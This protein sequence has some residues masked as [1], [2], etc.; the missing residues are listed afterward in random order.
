M[1]EAK[2]EDII[3]PRGRQQRGRLCLAPRVTL[4]ELKKRRI[5]FYNNT[6]LEFCNYSEIFPAIKKHMEKLGIR[7]FVDYRETVRGRS[8]EDLR[9]TA[10]ELAKGKF[11]AAVVALA[12]MGTS[13]ATTVLAI[14]MEKAGIPTVLISAP[15]GADLAEQ[16]AFY[17]AG[18][19]CLCPI[20]IFQA[21][22]KEAVAAEI[23]KQMDCVIES[24]IL[25][26]NRLSKRA[27]IKPRMDELPC[28]ADGFLSLGARAGS[29]KRKKVPGQFMEEVLDL[30]DSLHL[31]D[32]LPIIPP[33]QSRIA[34]MMKYCPFSPTE[35]L[36]AEPGP[37]GRDILVKDIVINAVLAGT[38]TSLPSV[39]IQLLDKRATHQDKVTTRV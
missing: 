25:P 15:P 12:D 35:V 3:D 7:E 27:I 31:G 37:A 28:S 19:L 22:S 4:A 39:Y 26:R 14:E 38:Q 13:P 30:F 10:R 36:I 33:T 5:L 24:L 32:G 16:V 23:N 21:S 2:V 9:R 20:D 17:R 11:S 1:S 34:K 18:R 29:A 6:K 8:T